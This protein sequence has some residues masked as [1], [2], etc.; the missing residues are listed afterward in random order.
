M[1]RGAEGERGIVGENERRGR[2][3]GILG[4]AGSGNPGWRPRV[5]ASKFKSFY[6]KH[7]F[8]GEWGDQVG[9]YTSLHVVNILN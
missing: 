9:M 3:G 5:S 7:M 2:R 8:L 4:Y 1:S 6:C